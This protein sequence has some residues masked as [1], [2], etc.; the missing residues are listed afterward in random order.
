V[1]FFFFFLSRIVFVLKKERHKYTRK[2]KLY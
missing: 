2:H 1:F